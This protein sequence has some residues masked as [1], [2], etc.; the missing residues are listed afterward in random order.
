M[1]G[2]RETC[3]MDQI[4]AHFYA[5][6]AEWNKYSVIPRGLGFMELLDMPHNRHMVVKHSEPDDGRAEPDTA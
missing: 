6:H 4:K 5:S 1:P 3:N 2:V